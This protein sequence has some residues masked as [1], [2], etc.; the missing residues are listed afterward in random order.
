M[1]NVDN[2]VHNYFLLKINGFLLWITLEKFC[3]FSTV[4]NV[5]KGGS[6][7]NFCENC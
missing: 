5:D 1:D 2:F 7:Q 3:G 6:E 4:D